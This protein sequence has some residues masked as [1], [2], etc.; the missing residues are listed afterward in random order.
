MRLLQLK[1]DDDV[2]LVEFIGRDTPPYAILS[3]TW[4]PS[5]EE[6]TYREVLRG[7][8][9]SK[10]GY[11]K[12]LNCGKQ[13]LKKELKYF[14]VDTCCIDKTSSTEL[15]EAI[16]SMFR[17]YREAAICFAYLDD[18]SPGI[19]VSS[20]STTTVR[21]LSR[22]WTLQE[23]VASRNLDFFACDWTLLGTK[24]DYSEALSAITGIHAP[25][26]VDQSITS[27]SI[28]Q[29]MSW[30]ARR[31]TTRP[32][33]IAYCLLGLFGVNMPLLYGEGTIKAFTRLQEEIM[34]DSDDQSLFAWSRPWERPT[35]DPTVLFW[36]RGLLAIYPAEFDGSGDIVS[37]PSLTRINPFSMTNAGLRITFPMTT[38]DPHKVALL[39]CHTHTDPTRLVTIHLTQL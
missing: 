29:R 36:P 30:A 2:D 27:F 13:A 21:W 10:A 17:W 8:G 20:W 7:T 12:I 39:N 24:A 22:G 9:K 23:L 5:K 38:V 15:S 18:V 33:D 35:T 3:H 31:V 32:E 14:W 16:N 37:M 11:R 19:S 26:L 6:V 4:G 1:D 34:K 28:A 25:A